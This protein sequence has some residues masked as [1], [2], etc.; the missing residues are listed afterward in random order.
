MK[1]FLALL[2]VLCLVFSLVACGKKN[3]GDTNTDA[4]GSSNAGDSGNADSG[5]E[6][7]G[8]N[9]TNTNTGEKPYAGTTLQ[10]WGLVGDQ[11]QKIDKINA[12]VWLWMVCAAIE[13][14]AYLNDVKLEYVSPYNQDSLIGSINSGAKP[15]FCIA[16]QE[17]PA[18]ANMG[19]IQPF[20]E[21]QK[22][23]LAAVVGS[24]SWFQTYRG[25]AY[26][27]L[28]PWTGA[29]TVKYNRTMMENYGVKTPQEYIDEGNWTWETFMEVARAC[30]KDTDG[31]GKL[32]TVGATVES[33]QRF[34][35]VVIEDPETGKLSSNMSSATNKKF[36]EM[37]YKG[38]VE[39]KSIHTSYR[40]VTDL[41]SPTIAMS[42]QDGEAYNFMQNQKILE[43]GDVIETCLPPSETKGG[44]PRLSLTNY[45]FF[46]PVGS[47]ATDAATDMIAYICQAGMK[48]IEDH[49]EGLYDSG[50]KGIT[51][52]CE[53]SKAWKELY[54][55]WLWERDDEY[56]K[57]KDDYNEEAYTDLLEA[58]LTLPKSPG[59]K[60]TNVNTTI[61]T[62]KTVYEAPP[63][64]SLATLE[65]A[66]NNQIA[67]Y[68]EMFLSE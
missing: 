20:N 32:D 1:K 57:I 58:Y 26:G 38:A 11:Y 59:R 29:E 62:S 28:P 4:T 41:K 55:D 53:Y 31:D 52:A 23:K 18:V 45:N 35:D 66:L 51:G 46:I 34:V 3:T 12:K 49:S 5:N 15:D 64:T 7:A 47:D 44:T 21:E 2:L 37:I 6:N 68:N 36:L 65:P 56:A 30:T 54:E 43:N 50:F 42:L 19:L 9:G 60:Y 40:V 13:E 22:A 14:W 17:F 33:M 67:K 25:E 39:D 61:Y 24:D 10:I 16:T 48:W 27:I 8:G 63:S